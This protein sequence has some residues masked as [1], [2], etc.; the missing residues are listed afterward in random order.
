MINLA[1]ILKQCEECNQV[2]NW[3]KCYFLVIEVIVLGH[4]ISQ[5]GIEVYRANVEV[6]EKLPPPVSVKVFRSFVGHVGFYQSF[7]KISQ[8]LHTHCANY[9]R[10]SA[11]LCLMILVWENL[12]RLRPS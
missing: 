9:S 11:S 3:E 5:I 2:L 4:R 12:E 10:R 8:K 1:E 6:I 7:I